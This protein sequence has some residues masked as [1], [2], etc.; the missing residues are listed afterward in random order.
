[1]G[2]A[3]LKSHTSEAEKAE[4]LDLIKNDELTRTLLESR[5]AEMLQTARR[6]NSQKYCYL[7]HKDMPS[8]MY[9]G[10]PYFSTMAYNT[11][12]LKITFF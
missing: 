10:P 2:L 5:I 3:N 1:M 9:A 8:G 4:S 7:H 11:S 12:S 6:I